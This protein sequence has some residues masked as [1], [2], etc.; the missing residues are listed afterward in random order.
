MVH[1]L[2]RTDDWDDVEVVEGAW[3][4]SKLSSSQCDVEHDDGRID[5]VPSGRSGELAD[6]YDVEARYRSSGHFVE[7][8]WALPP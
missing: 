8:L 3:W 6:D 1:H 4:L 5:C 7:P 2:R